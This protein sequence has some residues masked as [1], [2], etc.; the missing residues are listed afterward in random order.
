MAVCYPCRQECE[1]KITIQCHWCGTVENLKSAICNGNCSRKKEHMTSVCKDC[2][3]DAI[4][5]A[6]RI[7]YDTWDNTTYHYKQKLKNLDTDKM[8]SEIVHYYVD[9]KGYTIEKAVEDL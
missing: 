4:Q 8:F 3:L 2:Y 9:K 5:D 7:I 6:S 1:L